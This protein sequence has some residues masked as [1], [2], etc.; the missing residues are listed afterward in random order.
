MFGNLLGVIL[1]GVSKI[2]EHRF[3]F[4]G[5]FGDFLVSI[6]FIVVMKDLTNWLF[7]LAGMVVLSLALLLAIK[8][9][10]RFR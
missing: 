7:G 8:I 3:S 2:L 1:V 5:G 6:V 9:Y 4:T 10:K